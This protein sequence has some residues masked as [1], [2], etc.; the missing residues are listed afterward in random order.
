MPTRK[1]A[2][3]QRN[4][5]RHQARQ[6]LADLLGVSRRQIP[7][8][9]SNVELEETRNRIQVIK[10]RINR[11]VQELNEA[12]IREERTNAE[13]LE[14]AQTDPFDIPP[15]LEFERRDYVRSGRELIDSNFIAFVP[16][17]YPNR[18][19][20]HNFLLQNR[21]QI[22]G[23][24]NSERIRLDSSLKVRIGIFLTIKRLRNHQQNLFTD[25]IEVF[26]NDEYEVLY[27]R[28]F[29]S[30]NMAV[31]PSTN[32]DE[33]YDLTIMRIDGK[34]D[35]LSS[36]GSGWIIAAVTGVFIEVIKY[37]PLTASGYIE[38]PSGMPTRCN[39]VINIQNNDNKCFMWCVLRA[40][41]PVPHHPER[42]SNLRQYENELNFNGIEF[43]VSISD[44]TIKKFERQ[45]PNILIALYTWKVKG[46]VP[47]RIPPKNENKTLVRL[48]LIDDGEK[49]HYCWIK[50][51]SKLINNRSKNGH[52]QYICDWCLGHVTLDK[53]KHEEHMEDCLKVSKSPQKTEPAKEKNK[54][55]Y[56]YQLKKR[57]FVPYHIVADFEA[58]LAKIKVK[59]GKGEKYQ[60]H[61][62]CSYSYTKVRYDGVSEPKKEYIGEDAA[63]NFVITIINEYFKIRE[64][65]SNPKPMIPLTPEELITH[66][67]ATCCWICEEQY[68]Y[69]ETRVMDHCHITGKY[70]GSAHSNCNLQ[71]KIE[72]SKMHVPVVFHNGSG[73]D[74]HIV[75]QGIGAIECKQEISCIPKNYEKYLSYRIG[76]LRFIDSAEFAKISLEKFAENVGA[77]E[78][79]DENC[80]HLFRID[81]EKCFV[82]VDKFSIT[83]S[84]V[85]PHLLKYYLRK[86]VFPYDWFDSFEK[87]NATSLPSK[88][89]FYSRLHKR[90]ITDKQ[91][92]YAQE[93]WSAFNC[94]TFKDYHDVYLATDVLLLADCM[95]EFRC[96]SYK[97]YGLDPLWYYSAPG[98]FWDALF[99]VTGQK[100]ELITDMNMLLLVEKGMRGGISMVSLREAIANNE[101][102]K[103]Y[104]SDQ[105]KSWILYLDA[106]NL[107]GWAM[108]QYLP[109]GNFQWLLEADFMNL[110]TQLEKSAI[111]DDSDTGYILE[112]D[113]KYLK[114]LHLKYTDY[115]LAVESLEVLREWLSPYTEELIE[116]KGGK[117]LSVKKLV[118][119]LHDKKKYV[120]YYRN[121]Q[122]Y[123][124][125]GMVLETIHR[126]ISFDQKAWMKPY[127]ELNTYMR[128]QATTAFEK[129]F[130]KLANNAVFGKSMENLRKRQKVELVQPDSNPKRYRKLIA[131]PLFKGQKIFNEN[132]VVVQLKKSV[133]RIKHPYM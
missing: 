38:L 1:E 8:P 132:L 106:N 95:L 82:H 64:E 121:L 42:I 97:T 48:L 7:F 126:V 39:G 21:N 109:I 86:G 47:I 113:F 117:Y 25:D 76:N 36:C 34:I 24:I 16:S 110:R 37:T 102:C 116:R 50:D 112:V 29:K 68:K 2:A 41:H 124:S 30:T 98:L 88:E 6:E 100:L 123:L 91:Y 45:N 66:N 44:T 118:P 87:F 65:F 119:N 74:N 59:K 52:R 92:E 49:Q 51:L 11:E 5:I 62:P 99:K 79:K 105:L 115:P 18:Y 94:K 15:T 130:Y 114:E 32:L 63:K 40:L 111:K 10:D 108:L 90:G 129:D 77:G 13:F 125:Q 93:V 133:V 81:K 83:R 57:M 80:N 120:L 3:Q 96:T 75:M 12:R 26:Q 4:L 23:I 17:T 19:D 43:P 104:N 101:Y 73:Y 31:F 14:L 56:P 22:T 61:I 84:Q 131:D 58:I 35:K 33:I 85:K 28:P 70:R 128:T 72:P 53:K 27:N 78:C 20:Y 60:K 122:Y 103:Y 71:L 69:G 46:L 9:H 67:S 127:I 55:Y 89:A 54:V 107:Y